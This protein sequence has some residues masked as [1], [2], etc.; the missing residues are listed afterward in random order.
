MA[1]FSESLRDEYYRWVSI[2]SGEKLWNIAVKPEP[3]FVPFIGHGAFI[4]REVPRDTGLRK[5]V[6]ERA[7]GLFSSGKRSAYHDSYSHL[8]E[9]FEFEEPP[10]EI[11]D[12]KPLDDLLEFQIVMPEG[13]KVCHKRFEQFLYSL[14]ALEHPVSFEIIGLAGSISIQFVVA[15][16][17]VEIFCAN[18]EAFHPEI[19]LVNSGGNQLEMI[20]DNLVHQEVVSRELALEKEFFFPTRRFQDFSIDPYQAIFAALSL[21]QEE[22]AVILQMLIQ[23]CQNSWVKSLQTLVTNDQGGPFFPSRPDDLKSYLKKTEKPL[24]AVVCRMAS[25]GDSTRRCREL[26]RPVAAS[27]ESFEFQNE[28]VL[29][30]DFES[31]SVEKMI[32]LERRLSRRS[33]MILN[34]DELLSLVHL[35]GLDI[36]APNFARVAVDAPEVP[37]ELVRDTGL[38]I[39]TSNVGSDL[40]QVTLSPQER[41][42]HIHCIGASGVGKS[43]LITSCIQQDLEAGHGLALLDPHGDL[44]GSVLEHIPEHRKEDVVLFDP[45]DEEFPIGFNLLGARTYAEKNILAS[46]FV[47]IIQRLS[48][49]WGDNM[50]SVLGN[51]V[52][53]FLESD[54]GG[55]LLDLRKF[56]G[57][58]SF[59]NTVLETVS[60]PEVKYFWQ[61]EF[62]LVKGGAQ[63]SLITR[64]GSFLRQKLL[65]NMVA[66]K[67]E[68]LDFSSLMNEGKVFLAPL[69]QGLIGEECSFLIGSCLVSKFYQSALARQE[70]NEGDRKPFFLYLD[71]AHNFVTPSIASILSGARKYGLGLVLAHQDLEQFRS[72]SQS[73]L[74]SVLTNAHTRI[75][76]KLGDQDARKLEEGF[77]H[78]GADD[79]RKLGRGQAISRVGGS[80]NDFFLRT[81][82]PL[83]PNEE[84]LKRRDEVIAYSRMRY[85]TPRE[86]VEKSLVAYY[87]PPPKRKRAAAKKASSPKEPPEEKKSKKVEDQAERETT[88]E[89]VEVEAPSNESETKSAEVVKPEPK[90]EKPAGIPMVG[91]DELSKAVPYEFRKKGKTEGRGGAI[92]KAIQAQVK[93]QAN[94]MGLRATIEAP[95]PDGGGSVDVLVEGQTVTI[96]IEIALQSPVAQEVQNIRKCLCQ[97]FDE[98]VVVSDKRGHLQEI[99]QAAIA[100]GLGEKLRMVRFLDSNELAPFLSEFG[101]GLETNETENLGYSVKTKFVKKSSMEIEERKNRIHE[102]IAETKRKLEGE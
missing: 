85:G 25:V 17:D 76:F 98:I 75:C 65:R 87:E 59:R 100:E 89:T 73:T 55:T 41:L 32:D 23:P 37:N 53:A 9:P 77:E 38:A 31:E 16:D 81:P 15:P 102:M 22:E 93:Q 66:Q 3:H 101:N 8:L 14:G 36:H 13:E 52:M 12:M 64:L 24:F 30:D 20:L 33:G 49:S 69:A 67:G 62:P 97:G 45:A 4:D 21:A 63:A 50:S 6:F 91:S 1:R 96:A 51:A 99:K 84:C 46:D 54:E 34:C 39:G 79:L 95:L 40:E 43:T 19:M 60:E 92:H 70:M 5:N 80:Q 58:E 2:G 7:A 88:K 44:V 56:L 82:P 71:E 78:F 29:A 18:F 61:Y 86:E 74:S 83:E 28:F 57:D 35:P 90:E 94:G 42:K 26:L 72:R 48:T 27:F 47:S 68:R 11:V 10:D